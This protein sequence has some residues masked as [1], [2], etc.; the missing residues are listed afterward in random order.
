MKRVYQE[1]F[2]RERKN[3]DTI[4]DSYFDDVTKNIA[5]KSEIKSE[6]VLRHVS[7]MPKYLAF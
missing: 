6:M 7:K 2:S 5:Q 3:V 1:T 4:I